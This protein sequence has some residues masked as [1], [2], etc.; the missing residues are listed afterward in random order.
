MVAI[1]TGNDLLLRA[2]RG[3][4]TERTPVWLMRQAGRF[5]PQYQAFRA[6]CGLPLEELFRRPDLAAAITLLPRRLGVDALILFQDILTPLS[7]MGA[8]FIFRPG[9]VLEQPIRSAADV[10]SLRECEPAEALGFVVESIQRVNAELAGELPLLGFAGSPL[11][12]AAFMIEGGSPNG[13]GLRHTRALMQS[14]PALMHHLLWRLAEMT[15]AYLRMQVDAG[16]EAVQLFESVG[17]L[18]TA[19]EYETFAHPYHAA[20]FSRLGETVP[21]MLFVKEQ[22]LLDLMVATGADVL[23]VGR[24]VDLSRARREYGD[25]VAF[26]GNVDNRLLAE[27]S[28]DQIDDAVRQCVR[29][30]GHHGHILNLNH[31]LLKDTPFDNVC[32]LIDAC[33]ATRLDDEET[34]P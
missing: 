31:G 29:A 2:A 27:G 30:G 26:Q 9:P 8:H 17:D 16:V 18:L 7:P 15:G 5:D 3:E 22:P 10:D 1:T 23:S 24:C 20:V 34:G 21:R 32:R 25:R 12:L 6:R 33:K 13:G 19:R 4:R 14:D 11:T 28:P